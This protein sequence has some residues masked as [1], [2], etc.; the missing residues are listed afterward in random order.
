[1]LGVLGL[2]GATSNAGFAKSSAIGGK[3]RTE[4]AFPTS[5]EGDYKASD[6]LTY[7]VTI[8]LGPEFPFIGLK[9]LRDQGRSFG[10]RSSNT[11]TVAEVRASIITGRLKPKIQGGA[12]LEVP[13]N[14]FSLFA[15]F[16]THK[17]AA[18]D[19][20]LFYEDYLFVR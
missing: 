6:G 3:F 12:S 2:P 7:A 4:T 17:T 20:L 18:G 1:M 11:A 13:E 9:T 8:T 5:I 14:F 16:N 10:S 15:T 19:T